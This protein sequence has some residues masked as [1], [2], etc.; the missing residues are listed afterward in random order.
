MRSLNKN[1]SL[2]CFFFILVFNLSSI[3]ALKALELSNFSKD[4]KEALKPYQNLKELDQWSLFFSRESRPSLITEALP[5][6]LNSNPPEANLFLISQYFMNSQHPQWVIES[7]YPKASKISLF[8]SLTPIYYQA[9]FQQNNLDVLAKDLVTQLQYSSNQLPFLFSVVKQLAQKGYFPFT[10]LMLSNGSGTEI[11]F[12]QQVILFYFFFQTSRV[13]Q[14]ITILKTISSQTNFLNQLENP[15]ANFLRSQFNTIAST[16]YIN[17]DYIHYL[18]FYEL[19]QPYL[20]ADQMTYFLRANQYVKKMTQQKQMFFEGKYLEIISNINESS[21]TNRDL[22]RVCLLGT[23]STKLLEENKD[24]FDSAY[25]QLIKAVFSETPEVFS[26]R[27]TTVSI[28]LDD[29]ESLKLKEKFIFSDSFQN[30]ELLRAL[31]EIVKKVTL[32]SAELATF[33]ETEHQIWPLFLQESTFLDVLNIFLERNEYE[34]LKLFYLKNRKDL[35]TDSSQERAEYFYLKANFFLSNK[36][37]GKAFKAYLD[38]YPESPYRLE[39]T[40]LLSAL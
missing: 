28:Q 14:S 32:V 30:R 8:N 1:H 36:S 9:L 26:K 12:S 3:Q 34:P 37:E 13:P 22:Y 29:L 40:E 33:Y 27:L 25:W 18:K 17:A 35:Q 6:Y 24:L 5:W 20:E 23:G 15:Y 16:L 11:Q 4:L 21:E 10:N 7:L 31:Q 2:L 38:R 19:T 39:I